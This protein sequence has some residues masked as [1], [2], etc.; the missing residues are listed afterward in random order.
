[1][2][3]YLD[4]P[5]LRLLPPE[6]PDSFQLLPPEEQRVRGR[7]WIAMYGAGYEQ[8]H[9]WWFV[10]YDDPDWVAYMRQ[11]VARLPDDVREYAAMLSAR[12][13]HERQLAEQA[14]AGPQ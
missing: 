13:E 9:A 14:K 11:S 7:M 3:T 4:D 12:V 8:D 1:M 5:V 2:A 6:P 10:L